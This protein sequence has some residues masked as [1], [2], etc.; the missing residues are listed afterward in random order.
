MDLPYQI[1]KAKIDGTYR[2]SLRDNRTGRVLA[3]S[4]S[5]DPV[6]APQTMRNYQ[7]KLNTAFCLGVR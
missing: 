5:F 2:Y 3:M 1:Y 6:K 4:N 7:A